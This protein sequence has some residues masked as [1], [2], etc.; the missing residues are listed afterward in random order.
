MENPDV[1]YRKLQHKVDCYVEHMSNAIRAYEKTLH[2]TRV[3]L[4]ALYK[5]VQMP[6]FDCPVCG[7]TDE[8]HPECPWGD[9]V[10]SEEAIRQVLSH[11]EE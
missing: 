8:C 4:T 6:H 9:V 10:E 5:T 7:A 2:A 11:Y 1:E 3:A